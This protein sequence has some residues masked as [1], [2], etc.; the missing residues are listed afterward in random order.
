MK[1]S[2][3]ILIAF[4]GFI[5]LYMTAAF[6]EIRFRGIPNLFDDSN[7]IAETEDI[8]GIAHLVV[9]NLDWRITVLGSDRPRLEVRSIAGNLLHNLKHTISGDT[10]T[11]S[12]L[13]RDKNVRLK[14]AVYMPANSFTGMTVN[15]AEVNIE[16]LA[17]SELLIVQNGGRV[18]MMKNNQI[19]MLHLEVSGMANFSLVDGRVD[20]LSAQ[21]DNSQA[22]IH[23]P[24]RLLKG[25]LQNNAYLRMTGVEEVQFK[26]DTSSILHFY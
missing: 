17:Q 10:L 3:K 18:T 1:L 24:V 21:V 4:F 26:K 16:A 19:E 13:E 11:I 7:S 9:N 15:D 23:T 2:N 20:T 6:T 22:L 12:E 14:I 25:S 8:S 5:F